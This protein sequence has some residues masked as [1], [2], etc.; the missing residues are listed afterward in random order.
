LFEIKKSDLA[1]RIG[2]LHTNHG[3]VET[4]AYVPV[5]HPVKQKIPA[6][7]LRKM[8]FDLVITNAYITLKRY[9]DEAT[10]QGIHK[11]ID[12]D[13]VIMTDS[14]GYQVL[15]YG[16]IDVDYKKIAAF[17]KGIGTDIAIPLDRPTGLGLSKKK[18]V[19]Y[20]QHTLRV[21]KET[22]DTR[23]N[24]GQIWVG[25]IQGSEHSDL[26]KKSTRAL[27]DS[28]FQMLALGSPVEFMES[29]EYKLLAKM[30][31]TAKKLIPASIPLHLFGAG[32][33]LTIPL[34]V[35]L[36]CDTFDSASYILYAKHD[37]YIMEDGTAHLSE[38]AYFSC[39]CEVCTRLKP[40]EM[41][42]LDKEDRT[43]KLALHNLYAIK[44]EVDRVKEAIHEGRLWEYAI[45]KARAHPKL[46]ETV[47]TFT[48]NTSFFMETTPRFKENAVF[49][50]SK[51][52]QFR[53]EI[54][55]FHS[56]VRRFK[57]K[58]KILVIIPDGGIR[59]FYTSTEYHNLKKKFASKLDDIQFCQYNPYLGIIPLEL[60]DIYP[61]AHYVVSDT[62]FNQNEFPEFTKTWNTFLKRNKFKNIYAT[63]DDF[64]RYH[65]K[66][67]KTKIKFFN[68][69][70]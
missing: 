43:N 57:S 4:P 50:F 23:D 36:G 47:S 26:V 24:S 31:I 19:E 63:S 7:K 70:K 46:F 28:G 42:S 25:P 69:K 40:K 49:L 58:K 52:D 54:F 68:I 5:I 62:D 61:A 16:D 18:A 14:G 37:R 17:Q 51:E 45:R 32:H 12:Y 1:G 21:S 8:G 13:G 55:R 27:I 30:I 11:I 10:R 33:P 39:N 44:A 15:E 66:G 20:V 59:P 3:K 9:G 29:Y 64:L 48:N 53:P 2:I 38:V 56:L 67:L 41:L 22:L 35:A 6:R 60:S 65:S 34:A